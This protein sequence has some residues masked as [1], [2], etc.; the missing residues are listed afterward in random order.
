MS[1]NLEVKKEWG[2]VRETIFWLI[3]CALI[4]I[5]SLEGGYILRS[6]QIDWTEGEVQKLNSWVIDHGGR[7]EELE[8]TDRRDKTGSGKPIS[9]DGKT[10]GR[11][12][13]GVQGKTPQGK[14]AVK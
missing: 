12:P 3:V 11:N 9:P 13:D 1:D 7:I 6:R 8:I 4:A 5:A 2:S 10:R 14:D